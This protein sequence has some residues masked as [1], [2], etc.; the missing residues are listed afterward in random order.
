MNLHVL[1]QNQLKHC[2]TNCTGNGIATKRTEKLHTIVKGLR[3]FRRGYHGA[4]WM[5]ISDRLTQYDD[6]RHDR[7]TLEAPEMSANTAVSGLHFICY[8]N[9]PSSAH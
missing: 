8:A 4:N 2:Q 1:R 9:A 7:I 3:N 5:A 6:I